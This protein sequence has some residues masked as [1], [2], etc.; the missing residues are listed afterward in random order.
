MI[1]TIGGAR[2]EVRDVELLMPQHYPATLRR[3]VANLERDWE[4]AVAL[5]SPGRARVWL[6]YQAG[7]VLAFEANRI[8]LHQAL[9]AKPSPTGASGMARDRGVEHSPP[10]PPPPS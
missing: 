9:A 1:A 4:R 7:S 8:G 5:T 2:F 3:W 6:L 10:S